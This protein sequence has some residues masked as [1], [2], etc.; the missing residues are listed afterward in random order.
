MWFFSRK[1][2]NFWPLTQSRAFLPWNCTLLTRCRHRHWWNFDF[3]IRPVWCLWHLYLSINRSV[4][5]FLIWFLPAV[6]S[7]IFF[8]YLIISTVVLFWKIHHFKF[9][10]LLSQ[11]SRIKT[12][13]ASSFFV[14]RF[15]CLNSAASARAHHFW[16]LHVASLTRSS[17]TVYSST[18]L[19][20]IESSR[21]ERRVNKGMPNRWTRRCRQHSLSRQNLLL[22]YI[23]TGTEKEVKLRKK[24]SARWL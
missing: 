19:V 4:S 11:A 1:A 9:S 6:I 21:W 14:T 2:N 3:D 15:D 17:S 16:K 24:K 20:L 18:L 8:F 13:E 5:Y 10:K 22:S 12:P 23:L 7:F